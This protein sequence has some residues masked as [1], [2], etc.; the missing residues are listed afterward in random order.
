MFTIDFSLM[1][2]FLHIL[3]PLLL[4][5]LIRF[6]TALIFFVSGSRSGF[7]VATDHGPKHC[8]RLVP[9]SYRNLRHQRQTGHCSSWHQEQEYLSQAQRRVR[10]RRLRSSRQISQRHQRNRRAAQRTQ[11]HQTL[12]AARGNT[13]FL[14]MIRFGLASVCLT[15]F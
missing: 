13:T 9:S 5:F 11:R 4:F 3:P 14:I 8:Q 10:H 6:S 15:F 2:E 1:Y 12:H 7:F